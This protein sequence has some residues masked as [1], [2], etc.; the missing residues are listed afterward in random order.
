MFNSQAEVESFIGEFEAR[1]LPKERWTHQAHLVAGFWY[2]S[3][4]ATPKALDTIRRR[5]RAHNDAVGTP[6][7]DSSGYHETIT[8][9]YLNGITAH[10]A[11]HPTLPFDRSLAALLVSPM[12]KKEWPLTY[13]SSHLLFG[14]RA[15]RE[16]VEPDLRPLPMKASQ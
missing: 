1:R 7:T 4:H 11:A 14:V 2:L 6:N 15:R 12:A 5:I 9:L 13:Y 16:W 8:R 3:R 10:I